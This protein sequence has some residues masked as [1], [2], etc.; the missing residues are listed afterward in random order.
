MFFFLLFLKKTF[1]VSLE[2][3]N[4]GLTVWGSPICWFPLQASAKGWKSQEFCLCLS[5]LGVR[6]PSM[7]AIFC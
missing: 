5:H 6:G 7:W 4:L 2:S 1:F 3:Q